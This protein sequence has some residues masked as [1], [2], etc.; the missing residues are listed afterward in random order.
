MG[1]LALPIVLIIVILVVGA[2]ALSQMSKRTREREERA[3]SS[4]VES[5][6]YRVPAG[7]DPVAAVTALRREGF[8]AVEDHE[9]AGHEVL[10][11]CPAG[12]DRERARVR[13]VL[14]HQAP[15]NLDGDPTERSIVRFDDE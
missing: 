8:E 7:Q 4:A 13:A 9:S 15:L 10:I 11:P 2:V 3:K 12:K 14:E 5:L 1:A 6:R